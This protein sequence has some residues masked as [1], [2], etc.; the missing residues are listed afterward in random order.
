MDLEQWSTALELTGTSPEQSLS[1]VLPL[2]DNSSYVSE[3]Y[4]VTADRIDVFAP[5]QEAHAVTSNKQP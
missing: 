3:G 4:E 2:N 5:G 1:L